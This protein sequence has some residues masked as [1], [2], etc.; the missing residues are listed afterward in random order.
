M[1]GINCRFEEFF[2]QY[3]PL[4]LKSEKGKV[5]FFK[6][7]RDCY[8]TFL[9]M[10]KD[11]YPRGY[12]D[13]VHM[14]VGFGY[15]KNYDAERHIACCKPLGLEEEM[16][17]NWEDAESVKTQLEIICKS[18]QNLVETPFQRDMFLAAVNK[19]LFENKLI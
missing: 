13:M 14:L 8:Y 3:N 15:L 9:I 17:V 2:D 10:L 18:I 7:Y 11:R 4:A 12:I 5:L 16:L 1:K 19:Y 6:E